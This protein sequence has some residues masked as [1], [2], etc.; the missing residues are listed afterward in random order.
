[1]IHELHR[2]ALLEPNTSTCVHNYMPERACIPCRNC[3]AL[4]RNL[5]RTLAASTVVTVK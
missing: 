1:M 5:P 3:P 4:V 2:Y